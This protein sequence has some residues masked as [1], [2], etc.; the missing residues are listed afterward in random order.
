MWI[1]NGNGQAIFSMIEPQ[2]VL[3]YCRCF[4]PQIYPYNEAFDYELGDGEFS[5]NSVY[6]KGFSTVSPSI[7][8]KMMGPDAMILVFWMLSLKLTFSLSSFI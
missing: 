3:L 5:F 1:Y 2:S 6:S 8:H 4:W 7:S